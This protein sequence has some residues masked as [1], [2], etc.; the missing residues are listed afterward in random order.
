MPGGIGS[1][2]DYIKYVPE[3]KEPGKSW[4]LATNRIAGGS[5]DLSKQV[6]IYLADLPEGETVSIRIQILAGGWN[7][8]PVSGG[9]SNSLD[10]PLLPLAPLLEGFGPSTGTLTAETYDYSLVTHTHVFEWSRI[11]AQGNPVSWAVLPILDQALDP[12][13]PGPEY[14][15]ASLS[16]VIDVDDQ[17]VFIRVKSVYNGL[18]GAPLQWK[19][20]VGVAAP[21]ASTPMIDAQGVH[22]TWTNRSSLDGTISIV[23][24]GGHVAFDTGAP[25]WLASG[26]SRTVVNFTDVPPAPGLYTYFVRF[27]S[28]VNSSDSNSCYPI[29]VTIPGGK[30]FTDGTVSNL[31]GSILGMR[32]N[33]DTFHGEGSDGVVTEQD[34]SGKVLS[35]E[36]IGNMAWIEGPEFFAIDALEQPHLEY[37]NYESNGVI[38]HHTW[39]D[40][41]GWHDESMP[42]PRVFGPLVCD[43]ANQLSMIGLS[44]PV[45]LYTGTQGNWTYNPTGISMA[46]DSFDQNKSRLNVA[47]APDGTRY[48]LGSGTSLG[49][50]AP[51][52]LFRQKH[53]GQ[54][55]LL[56]FPSFTNGGA[57]EIRVDAICVDN[58]GVVYLIRNDGHTP[59]LQTLTGDVFSNPVTI[60][61]PSGFSSMGLYGNPGIGNTTGILYDPSSNRIAW[62]LY[63]SGHSL[64]GLYENGAWTFQVVGP[65]LEF[66]GFQEGKLKVFY[67][68]NA[69]PGTLWSTDHEQ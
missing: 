66:M 37:Y 21:L 49:T 47:A 33:G 32:S 29:W 57:S 27:T 10:Q 44:S 65:R 50:S 12:T 52:G 42:S 48:V 6:P 31:H 1:Y 64:I 3:I 61:V 17:D 69:F 67:S 24:V 30:V 56:Q 40:Q 55:E 20:H 45:N 41:S 25:V 46:I 9:A 11:D 22:L 23:R 7:G 16:N 34:S 2:S 54:P 14:R 58:D 5:Y 63:N 43:G 68:G 39:E 62:G 53:G 8:T 15:I 38:T 18:I 36:T 26:L 13:Y 59:F 19:V 51:Q 28:N 35:T 4:I 60:P